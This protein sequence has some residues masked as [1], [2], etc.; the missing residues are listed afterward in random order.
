MDGQP[1]P[2]RAAEPTPPRFVAIALGSAVAP[3]VL[4]TA[5]LV[6]SGSTALT[7]AAALLLAVAFIV[8]ALRW[9]ARVAGGW[10]GVSLGSRVGIA[11]AIVTYHTIAFPAA[12]IVR[13]LFFASPTT[14]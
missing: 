11:L 4:Q 7:L 9:Q 3:F 8:V 1:P 12:H 14:A 10:E 5:V 2:R 13:A 6:W